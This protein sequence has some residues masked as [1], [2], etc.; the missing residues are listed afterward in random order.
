MRDS[1][2]HIREVSIGVSHKSSLQGNIAELGNNV[3]QYGTRDQGD[4]FTRTTEAIANY[5]G[6]E[7]T[8]EMRL[9]MKNQKEKE[10]KEPIM[11]D[12]E[13]AKLPFMMKKYKTE[14]KQFYFKQERYEEHKA[15]IFVIVKGQRTLNMK[16]KVEI[17]QGHDSK[18]ANDDVISKTAGQ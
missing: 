4:K 17:L 6:R 10:P 8:K 14:L 5:A 1:G 2:D 13:E 3:Y 9:L 15:K 12:K 11:W 7:Y 16:N 18:E